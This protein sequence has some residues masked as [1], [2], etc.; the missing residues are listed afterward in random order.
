MRVAT[1]FIATQAQTDIQRAQLELFT[2]Q[3]Q[4]GSERNATDLKGYGP[5]ARQLVSARGYEARADARIDAAVLAETRTGTQEVALD[6]LQ[7]AAQSARTAVTE[8]LATDSGDE[9]L[10]R[11]VFSFQT[12]LGA[13][14]TSHAGAYV[15]G[16]VRENA[17]PVNV[18]TLDQLEAAASAADV[19]D[20]SPRRATI[21]LDNT[22]SMDIAPLADE[23][24]EP[25]MEQLRRIKVADTTLGPFQGKLTDAQKTE[26]TAIVTNLDTVIEGVTRVQSENGGV[27]Q[28][29]DDISRRLT[30]QSDYYATVAADIEGVDLAEVATRLTAAQQ[31]LQ[32]SVQAYNAIR[33]VSLVNFLR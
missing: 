5:S 15:F 33:D 8:A 19:F 25:L 11:V 18:D 3:Q 6:A 1:S 30:R 23:A 27:Q 2:A 17:E 16:G 7:E 24:G 10:S 21:Q 28:R 14:N 29:I 22:Y 31:Q 32:A 26:L 4:A 20:N 12:A 13:L 9:L